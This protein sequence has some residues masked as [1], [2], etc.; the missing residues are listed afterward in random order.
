ME[1]I[2]KRVRASRTLVFIGLLIVSLAIFTIVPRRELGTAAEHHMTHSIS[3]S[4]VSTPVTV[5]M[6]INAE[7]RPYLALLN[8]TYSPEPVD[9]TQVQ[10]HFNPGDAGQQALQITWI[11]NSPTTVVADFMIATYETHFVSPILNLDD[12][13]REEVRSTQFYPLEDPI[14]QRTA[15]EVLGRIR[16]G[17]NTEK[18]RAVYDWM[19]ENI[20]YNGRMTGVHN[21]VE[22]LR[23]REAVC[24]G[25]AYTFATL[26]RALGVPARVFYGNIMEPPLSPLTGVFWQKHAWAEFWDGANWQPV[27]PTLGSFGSLGI[28]QYVHGSFGLWSMNVYSDRGMVWPTNRDGRVSVSECGLDWSKFVQYRTTAWVH[29]WMITDSVSVVMTDRRAAGIFLIL[30]GSVY[31]MRR[32]IQQYL[33][34]DIFASIPEPTPPYFA[35]IAERSLKELLGESSAK[36][37]IYHMGGSEILRDPRALQK[38]IDAIFGPQAYIVLEHILARTMESACALNTATSSE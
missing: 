10:I 26:S 36:A 22:V 38:G 1:A 20:Q 17:S 32:R 19:R 37:A 18:A 21:P 9:V 6:L 2:A 27:D 8:A 12:S 13:N 25:I 11:I 14:V 29:L 3:F 16:W 4:R 5:R 23:Q 33:R 24:E 34:P 30:I 7:S 31:M 35:D 15:N 28:H